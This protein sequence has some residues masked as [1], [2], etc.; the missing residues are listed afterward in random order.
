MIR[1]AVDP[2]VEESSVNRPHATD[3]ITYLFSSMLVPI[4]SVSGGTSEEKVSETPSSL[5]LVGA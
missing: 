4:V 5:I 3:R 1:G 2:Y